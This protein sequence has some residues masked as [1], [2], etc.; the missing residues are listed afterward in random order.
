MKRERTPRNPGAACK[1]ETAFFSLGG[2]LLTMTMGLGI[3]HA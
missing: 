3:S 1:Y 2:M